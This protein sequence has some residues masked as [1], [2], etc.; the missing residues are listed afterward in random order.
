[1]RWNTFSRSV[2]F[3]ALAAGSVLPWLLLAR[4]AFGAERALVL[5]LVGVVAA[6]LGGLAPKR[7]RRVAVFVAA[8]CVALGVAVV[9]RTAT[10]LV[11][12]LGAV[13]ALGRSAFLYQAPA[14]RAV[15]TEAVLVG[16]GLLF[17]RFLIGHSLLALVLALWGFFLVQSL[18]FLLGGVRGRAGS[19][20][21]PDPFQDA[22]GRALALLDR[23]VM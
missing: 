23:S 16:G 15:L 4:P 21:H 22:C 20:R 5:Y 8:A 18:Y 3:A 13:L 11:L 19:G 17:V 10:E 1:M 9:A 6:Y 12:G 14:T 2:L 7:G